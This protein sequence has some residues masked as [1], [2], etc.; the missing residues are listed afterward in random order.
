MCCKLPEETQT[1]GELLRQ[2]ASR[3]KEANIEGP[4]RDARRLL[5]FTTGYSSTQLIADEYAE[6][7]EKTVSAFIKLIERRASGEPVSRILGKREFWGL[8]FNISPDV[9]DPR[10]DTETIVEVILQEWRDTDKSVLDLG[11]GSG[12]ILLSVLHEKQAAKG[13]GLDQSADALKIA[14]QNAEDLEIGQRAAFLQSD[15]FSALEKDHL[16]DIIV[17]NPPYI[18]T[19]DINMLDVDVQ[20]FDPMSALD[21]GED[22]LDDYRS[23]IAQAKNHM[24]ENGLLVFE[25]G[26]NQA[27]DVAEL[28]RYSGFSDINY[29]KDLAGVKRCVYARQ[30]S[31]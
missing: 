22:G 26:Y 13:W 21:G 6:A 7:D 5:E 4:V 17:S 11:T 31:V 24:T 2:G 10:P 18:P 16:F 25:V 27:D 14:K 28:L 3:L 8:S 30:T 15:W 20:K 23:I 12:C 1:L 9:L 19:S 29:K